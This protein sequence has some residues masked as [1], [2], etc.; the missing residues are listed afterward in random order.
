MNVLIVK[1]AAKVRTI[2]KYLRI[3]L[4]RQRTPPLPNFA[5]TR[6]PAAG[7]YGEGSRALKGRGKSNTGECHHG[8]PLDRVRPGPRTT[9]RWL[10][11]ERCR[12]AGR[13]T[14]TMAG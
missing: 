13:A 8:G 7:G 2:Q 11:P 5:V 12:R 10:E 14:R 4:P 1:S 6:Y 9:I 3:R